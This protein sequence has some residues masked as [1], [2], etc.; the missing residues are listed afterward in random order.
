LAKPFPSITNFRKKIKDLARDFDAVLAGRTDPEAVQLIQGAM[1]AI[2]R[3]PVAKAL[4]RSAFDSEGLLRLWDAMGSFRKFYTME[5][6]DSAFQNLIGWLYES[7]KFTKDIMLAKSGEFASSLVSACEKHG[8]KI[9]VTNHAL[10]FDVLTPG[11]KAGVRLQATDHLASVDL[12]YK[13]KT[14]RAVSVAGES[15]GRTTIAEGVAQLEALPG[16]ADTKTIWLNGK[17]AQ[18][19]KDLH[20]RIAAAL[21]QL[22]IP[23]NKSN[24]IVADMVKEAGATPYKR[25]VLFPRE[26]AAQTLAPTPAGRGI[27]HIPHAVPYN[28]MYELAT[29]LGVLFGLFARR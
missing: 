28:E 19:G 15:K 4:L 10:Y 14:S 2:L 17:S 12:S 21:E 11:N 13:G 6:V 24:A 23:P 27:E 20:L 1:A 18:M 8:F 26:T 22:G 25:V 7:T 9:D 16:R 3:H 5:Q 29:E